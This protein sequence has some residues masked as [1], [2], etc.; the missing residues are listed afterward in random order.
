MKFKGWETSVKYEHYMPILIWIEHR[1]GEPIPEDMKFKGWQTSKGQY[2]F[3][4]IHYWI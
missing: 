1:K 2:N 4:P 3:K